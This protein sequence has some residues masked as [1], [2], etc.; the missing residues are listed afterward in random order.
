[1]VAQLKLTDFMKQKKLVKKFPVF[2]RNRFIAVFTK[3]VTGPYPEPNE[4]VT[5]PQFVS[6]RSIFILSSYLRLTNSMEANTSWD[7]TTHSA[8]QE[9]SKNFGNPKVHYRVHNNP[10]LVRYSNPDESSPH[11]PILFV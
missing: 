10:P 11:R 9:F 2:Y 3:P 8:T 4:S 7:A 5:D 6:W 1:M